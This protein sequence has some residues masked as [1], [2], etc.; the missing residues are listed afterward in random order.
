MKSFFSRSKVWLLILLFAGYFGVYN[1]LRYQTLHSAYFDLGIMHQTVF[2]TY[3]A[4]VTG[5][6]GRILELTDPHGSANFMRAAV[7]VDMIM[8][9]FA[10]LYFINPSPATL[11]VAQAVIVALGGWAVYQIAL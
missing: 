8:A 7:H 5:E 1:V 9:L 2:N 11:V 3:R 6:Y 4:L 10:G